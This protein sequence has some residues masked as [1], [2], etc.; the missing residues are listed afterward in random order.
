MAFIPSPA[1]TGGGGGLIKTGYGG[2]G[3]PAKYVWLSTYSGQMHAWYLDQDF[4]SIVPRVNQYNQSHTPSSYINPHGGD[5]YLPQSNQ[6]YANA[7]ATGYGQHHNRNSSNQVGSSSAFPPMSASMMSNKGNCFVGHYASGSWCDMI[8]HGNGYGISYSRHYFNSDHPDK[9]INYAM[10]GSTIRAKDLGLSCQT[11]HDTEA[12]DAEG[13]VR[14]DI[15]QLTSSLAPTFT[16]N[17][18]QN[19][20]ASYNHKLKKLLVFSNNTG[21]QFNCVIYTGIDFDANP[22]PK[23]AFAAAGV[24]RETPFSLDLSNSWP[25]T[26]NETRYNLHLI[27]C[28]DGGV[29]AASWHKGNGLRAWRFDPPSDGSL[30]TATYLGGTSGTTS[31]GA[32]QG[33]EFG[34]SMLQST[35]GKTV[36]IM[37]PYYYYHAGCMAHFLDKVNSNSTISVI[38]DTNTGDV[39]YVVPYRDDGFAFFQGGNVYANSSGGGY[40]SQWVTRTSSN[41][42]ATSGINNLQH[43]TNPN[44]MFHKFHVENTTTY[45]SLFQCTDYH[46]HPYNYGARSETS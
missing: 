17:N 30:V 32:D 26:D 37:A 38:Q 42:T 18:T 9:R 4:N 15:A 23:A 13:T 24:G 10:F 22:S 43:T 3:S 1:S 28:N 6:Q 46:A 16:F 2:L 41:E 45:P 12:H 40:I 31:Y 20:N 34:T 14:Q 7:G 39:R 25:T 5:V 27:L 11:N 44:Q 8:E 19:H 29:R 21:S 33:T 36:C 35:D